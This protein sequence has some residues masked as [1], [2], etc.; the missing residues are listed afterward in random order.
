MAEEFNISWI[1]VLDEGIIQCFNKYTP[2]FMCDGHK[3]HPF[4]NKIQTTCC[5]LPPIR[6]RSQIVE[7]KDGPHQLGKMENNELGKT[8]SLMLRICRP[9]FG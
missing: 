6:W 2:G 5:G 3:P 9:M 1:N 4:G 7:G 8:T